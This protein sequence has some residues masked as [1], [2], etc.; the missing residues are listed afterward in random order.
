[1]ELVLTS[2]HFMTLD[3]FYVLRRKALFNQATSWLLGKSARLFNFQDLHDQLKPQRKYVGVRQIRTAQIVGSVGRCGDFDR[4]FRPLK[5]HLA[6]RW[7]RV[8]LQ[9]GNWPPIRVYKV[10]EVYYVED[11]H[12]RVSAAHYW[13]IEFIDAEIWEYSLITLSGSEFEGLQRIGGQVKDGVA[14]IAPADRAY[15]AGVD[16]A[17]GADPFVAG[18]MRV[19]VNDVVAGARS[20]EI[21]QLGP[22]VSMEQSQRRAFKGEAVECCHAS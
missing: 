12:H 3:T 20:D 8:V 9:K 4:E 21:F 14:G 11:G 13:G 6:D 10:G 16:Y 19:A 1:M 2:E 18:G 17:G 15:A 7:S 5:R 22:V